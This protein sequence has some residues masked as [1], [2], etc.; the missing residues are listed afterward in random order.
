MAAVAA[1][2]AASS[3]SAALGSAFVGGAANVSGGLLSGRLNADYSRELAQQSYALGQKAQVNSASNMVSGFQKAGLSPALAANGNFSAPAGYSG[4]MGNTDAKPNVDLAQAM[5]I[6]KNNDLLDAQIAGTNE[7]T[8]AQKIKNDREEQKDSSARKAL[9]N[10]IASFADDDR[11]TDDQK[12]IFAEMKADLDEDFI[13]V[14]KSYNLGTLEGLE[15]VP[16]FREKIATNAANEFESY[17]KAKVKEGMIRDEDSVKA[18]QEIDKLNNKKLQSEIYQLAGL[19][20][21]LMADIDLDAA[22]IAHL[23]NLD[24]QIQAQVRKDYNHE[25]TLQILDGNYKQAALNLATGALN[26]FATGAGAGTG[27]GGANKLLGLAKSAPTRLASNKAYNKSVLKVIDNNS[28]VYHN[29]S[30]ASNVGSHSNHFNV[31]ARF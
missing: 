26:A 10:S 28:S 2:A 17:Y 22:E 15:Q 12:Q 25:I 16:A 9:L 14:S 21:K 30:R 5:A 8:R 6:D 24:K 27:L 23:A 20:A 1:T 4:P 18:A 3:S 7:A 31:D 29:I 19:Y 13:N 11:L